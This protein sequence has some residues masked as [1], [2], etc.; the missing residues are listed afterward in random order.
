MWRRAAACLLAVGFGLP[1]GAVLTPPGM[2]LVATKAQ[3]AGAARGEWSVQTRNGF[4]RM[5]YKFE[6][7]VGAEVKVS[8]GIVVVTFRSPVD[9]D[10]EKLQ[11]ALPEWIGAARTDPDGTA[12]R[13]ALNRKVAVNMMPA[14]DKVFIDLLPDGWTGVPPGLPQDVV[15]ELSRR[16]R[17]AEKL[18]RL[19]RLRAEMARRAPVKI[20]VGNTPTFTRF[21]FDLPEKVAVATERDGD[22]VVLT[23]DAPLK[24]DAQYARSALPGF[25]SGFDINTGMDTVAI[26]LTLAAPADLRNFREDNTF[27]LDLT[28][29]GAPEQSVKATPKPKEA[30]KEPA[31]EAA[32]EPPVDPREQAAK[33]LKAI[34]AKPPGPQAP[35]VVAVA[36]PEPIKAAPAAK[37]PVKDEPAKAEPIKAEP[38]KQEA[39]KP[40][41]AKAEAPSQQPAPIAQPASSGLVKAE[42]R[43]DG[44]AISLVFPLPQE[45]TAAVFRR[46]DYLWVVLDTDRPIDTAAF[47]LDPSR[48]IRS[49]QSMAT[50]QGQVLRIALARPRL[51]SFTLDPAGLAIRLGDNALTAGANAVV[52]RSRAGQGRALLAVTL[53]RPAKLHRVLDP[54]VGDS[55]LVATAGAPAI[56]M[57]R[58]QDFVEVKLLTSVHG[59]AVLPVADDIE[60]EI[61]GDKVVLSRPEGLVLS[62]PSRVPR[63]NSGAPRVMAFDPRLW[64]VDRAAEYNERHSELMQEVAN[65]PDTRRSAARL[66]LA[67]FYFSKMMGA[68]AR[69]VVET[70]LR[71]DK[72]MQEEPSVLV[73]RAVADLLGARPKDALTHLNNPLLGNQQ[74]AQLWRAVAMEME[75]HH[76]QA[77]E[78]FRASEAAIAT[79]PTELQR[80]ALAVALRAAISTRDFGE[81]QRLL[82]DFDA[83]GVTDDSMDELTLLTGRTAEGLGR[84][85]EAV[86]RYELLADKHSPAGVEARMRLALARKAAGEASSENLVNE[87]QSILVIWRGDDVELEAMRE[88]GRVY[89]E[90]GKYREAFSLMSSAMKIDEQSDFSRSLYEDSQK[91]FEQIFIDGEGEKLSPIEALALFYDFKMLT[92]VGR[93]GDEMVRRLADRLAQVDL[94]DEA[95]NLLE[96]QIDKRLQGAARAQVAVRLAFI[97]LSARQPDRALQVLR[98]T[99]MP[100]LPATLRTQRMLLEARALAELGR[101]DAALEIVAG[102]NGKDADRLR[103]DIL[104]S[105]KRWRDAGEAVEKALGEAWREDIP[106]SDQDRSA[107]LRAAIAYS[108]GEDAIGMERL[109]SKFAGKMANTPDSRAF[110]VV[111]A[112]VAS[113]GIEFREIAR[114]IAAVDTLSGFLAD[115][116]QRYPDAGG[117]RSPAPPETKP[118]AAPGPQSKAAPEA[119]AKP[120]PKS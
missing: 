13:I 73:M 45:T 46:N 32:K 75:G 37:E 95:S 27:I 5:I 78:G 15:D 17:D 84:R 101:I 43:R 62:E 41:P 80:F 24:F 34:A 19:E 26:T 93:R 8:N 104:W 115:M 76:A 48:S 2:A 53:D 87:L 119:T 69:G 54:D 12:L 94:L 86:A 20:R 120:A 96:H 59:L 10:V 36:K 28:P 3:A 110:E 81:A 57:L 29:T 44:D 25:V 91:K 40:Q 47:S 52:A 14:G 118:A 113:R 65:A 102:M 97:R 22:N 111:S 21:S 105:A 99:R 112:P 114:Q 64:G 39:A 55:L 49:V 58:A 68:E 63:R 42:L 77:A 100:E 92:P 71:E 106:L 67:R 23:F 51:A 88:L 4:A 30:A 56:G 109:R 33:E 107:L 72:R 50:S 35:P 103:A 6:R 66:A 61:A 83:V 85:D 38:V 89:L 60:A 16:A 116:R 70:V 90:D 18:A 108:L 74:D 11:A 82:N 31:K 1:G 79:L 7:E 98:Q 9:L 117:T